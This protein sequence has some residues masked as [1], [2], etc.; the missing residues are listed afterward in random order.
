MVV[1]Q[2]NGAG[3][4]LPSTRVAVRTDAGDTLTFA[5]LSV[6]QAL[7]IPHGFG[8]S[9]GQSYLFFDGR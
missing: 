8:T 5:G 7:A 2:N 4:V 9:G 3:K 1:G 6:A